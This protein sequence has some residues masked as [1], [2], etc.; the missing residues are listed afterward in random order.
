M[1]GSIY[2]YC[3]PNKEKGDFEPPQPKGSVYLSY[4]PNCMGLLLLPIKKKKDKEPINPAVGRLNVV[5]TPSTGADD[6]GEDVPK[7]TDPSGVSIQFRSVDKFE[8]EIKATMAK[9]ATS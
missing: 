9:P 1:V 3:R 6:S 8:K 5:Y 2:P 4:T 7:I